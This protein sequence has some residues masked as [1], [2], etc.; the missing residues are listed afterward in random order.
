MC[1]LW[2]QQEGR[3]EGPVCSQSSPW[4]H[5]RG[6]AST[7][8]SAPAWGPPGPSSLTPDPTL[9]LSRHPPKVTRTTFL[10][11][12]SGRLHSATLLRA[13]WEAVPSFPELHSR[14]L[15]GSFPQTL[16]LAQ[17]RQCPPP[18]RMRQAQRPP[19]KLNT[20][21]STSSARSCS[22]PAHGL[23]RH[24]RGLCSKPLLS[25]RSLA[26]PT[27]T[28][29][30]PALAFFVP[31]L[32]TPLTDACGHCMPACPNWGASL[33]ETGPGSALVQCSARG[34]RTLPAAWWRLRKHLRAG[35]TTPFRTDVVLS[36]DN[37]R[38]NSPGGG[39][40]RGMHKDRKT[41]AGHLQTCRES[42]LTGLRS[43]RSTPP[44]P[45]NT[46]AR[47]CSEA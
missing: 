26:S 23:P 24:P 33:P 1:W 13:N 38:G 39:R 37:G 46:S 43:P 19:P 41:Q 15:H 9:P 4:P 32:D 35:Y 11:Q 31:L 7:V 16:S 45:R 3:S 6:P 5:H 8:T 30:P 10:E 34:P 18:G 27:Q 14:S 36:P 47:R 44:E 17:P 12:N 29:L 28:A 2:K 20:P 22:C 42:R 40:G 25:T 21:T